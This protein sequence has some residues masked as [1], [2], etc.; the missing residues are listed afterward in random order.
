M[1]NYLILTIGWFLG[2]AAVSAVKAIGI[3]Q[4]QPQL[5]YLDAGRIVFVQ[6]FG[7]YV[8]GLIALLIGLFAMPDFFKNVLTLDDQ[9]GIKAGSQLSVIVKW[10]RISS[11]GFGVAAQILLLQFVFKVN[12]WATKLN[13]KKEAQLP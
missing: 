8:I 2:Q 1:N 11:V 10:F 4:K 6:G 9:N 3:Q 7:S 5:G 12:D 13:D